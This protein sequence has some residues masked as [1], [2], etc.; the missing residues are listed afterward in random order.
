MDTVDTNVTPEDTQDAHPDQ[1]KSQDL[2]PSFDT[3]NYPRT[4]INVFLEKKD[5]K[6]DKKKDKKEAKK[7]KKDNKKSKKEQN[8]SKGMFHA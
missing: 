3:K 6:K 1:I 2:L 8:Q 5:A 7:D 4:N